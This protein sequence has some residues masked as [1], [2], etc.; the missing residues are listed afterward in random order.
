MSLFISNL[1]FKRPN[2]ENLLNNINFEV[3]NGELLIIQGESG[4]GKTTLLN[5][6]SGLIKVL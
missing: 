5:I 1:S 2:E 4:C 6:I 3:A